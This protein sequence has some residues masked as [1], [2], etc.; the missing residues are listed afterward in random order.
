[1]TVIGREP[2]DDVLVVELDEATETL[3]RLLEVLER[4]EGLDVVLD[5]LARTALLAIAG[6][7]A[8]TVTVHEDA[9][10]R[11]VSATSAHVVPVDQVRYAAGEGPD[12]EAAV[13]RKPPR[14][15]VAE[16]GGPVACVCRG[17][18]GRGC[19]VVLVGAV[20]DPRRR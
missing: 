8:V 9:G 12:L 10:P 3:E 5:R 15:S 18:A 16:V 1:V 11:T 7:D 14:V 17:R 20:G 19:S 4:E 2:A 13:T 6:A